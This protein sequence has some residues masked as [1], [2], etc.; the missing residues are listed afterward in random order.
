MNNSD[1]TF[2]INVISWTAIW[3]TIGSFL[4]FIPGFPA[5]WL[6][7]IFGVLFG[8]VGLLLIT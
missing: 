8:F 6:T 5:W 2:L 1:R 3:F 7:G 4:S